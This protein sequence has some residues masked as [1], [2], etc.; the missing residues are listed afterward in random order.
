MVNTLYPPLVVGGA[1]KSVSL[2][3]EAL[4][5]SGDEVSVA[6]LHP[7][8]TTE[9]EERNGVRVYRLPLANIYWPFG[10]GRKRGV[11]AKM[12]WHLLDCWN[13][14]AARRFGRVLDAE[15]PDVVH[16]NNVLGFSAAIFGEVKRRRIRLV[17]TLRDYSMVCA[18]GTLFRD[19]RICERRCADC[20]LLTANRKLLSRRVDAVVANS[21]YVLGAHE[22]RGWFRGVPGEVIY[23]IAEAAKAGAAA[24]DA[25]DGDFRDDD[26]LIFGFIGKIE[27]EKGIEVLL[28]ATELI[29][30]PGWRLRI[31]GKGLDGYVAAL[32]RRFADERIE[33]LGFAEPGEFY[34]SIDVSVIA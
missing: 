26:T 23:N 5:R 11:P 19:G 22:G 1:E 15:K 20:A 30:R 25:D 4:A 12:L 14:V 10:R 13:P 31:A 7:G 32:R 29:G 17:H 34:R 6:T 33:W 24:K 3:A 28:R 9:V 2:L 18:R 21:E 8:R 27:E 16:T